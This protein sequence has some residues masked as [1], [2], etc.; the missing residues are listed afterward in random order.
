LLTSTF[1]KPGT[2]TIKLG[3]EESSWSTSAEDGGTPEANFTNGSENLK[4]FFL[5]YRKKISQT[6]SIAVSIPPPPPP[7]FPSFFCFPIEDAGFKF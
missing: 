5:I 7:T 1:P 6:L 4:K 3:I 2:L